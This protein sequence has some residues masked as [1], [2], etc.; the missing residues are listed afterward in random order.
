ML[1]RYERSENHTEDSSDD[2]CEFDVRRISQKVLIMNKLNHLLDTLRDN[3][4]VHNCRIKN[5]YD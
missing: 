3:H 5:M 1:I 4:G 2:D